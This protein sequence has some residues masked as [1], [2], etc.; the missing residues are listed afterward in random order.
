M[1]VLTPDRIDQESSL[2]LLVVGFSRVGLIAAEVLTY[3]FRIGDS[4]M[5]VLEVLTLVAI[6]NIDSFHRG[7]DLI[8]SP[9]GINISDNSYLILWWMNKAQGRA[10]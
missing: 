3:Q 5:K 7:S 8:G 6:E 2:G 1:A 9:V 4:E 10:I